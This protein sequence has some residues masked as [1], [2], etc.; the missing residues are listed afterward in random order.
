MR[1]TDGKPASTVPLGTLAVWP[2]NQIG[3][4]EDPQLL[5]IARDTI[6]QRGFN[7][8]PLVPPAMARVGYDPAKLL[9]GLRK[10]ALENGY[11]NGYILFFGG[12]VESQAQFPRR[13]NEMMLQSFSGVLRLFPVWPKDHDASFGN[14]SC[15]RRVP[16]FK[17][18]ESSRGEGIW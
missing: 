18:I 14:P 4:G 12:G 15:L 13:V 2:A 3:L 10:D 11:P 1:V 9:A 17:R 6:N 5:K 7:D 8:H 16:G